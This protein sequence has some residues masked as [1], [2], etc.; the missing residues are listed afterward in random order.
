MCFARKIALVALC[1]TL[2]TNLWAQEDASCKEVGYNNEGL[3]VDLGVGLWGIPIPTDYDGDGLTDLLVSCPDKPYK[4][5]YYFRNVGSLDKPLFDKAKRIDAK[6]YNNI[7]ISV[8]D[9]KEYVLSAGKEWTN[10]NKKR[11]KAPKAITYTGEV[12]GATYKKSRS[13]MWSYVDWENDGD[14]DILVGIDT[15]DDYGWDNT[16]N[17]KGVWTNGPLHGYVYLLENVNGDYV[18]TGK[19]EAGG[20]IIDTYGAPI[21]ALPIGMVMVIWISSVASLLMA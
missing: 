13:N 7:K 14:L 17:D 18:N 20:E 21:L 6:G 16:Y 19:I 2:V 5:L 4:G 15:W 8:V 10:F 3:V 1:A 9:G 11:Y 12:L